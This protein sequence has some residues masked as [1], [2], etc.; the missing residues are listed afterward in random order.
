M[1]PTFVTFIKNIWLRFFPRKECCPHCGVVFINQEITRKYCS[2]RC[3]N[4]AAQ[5]RNMARLRNRGH[6]AFDR[7]WKSGRMSRGQAYKWASRVVRRPVS[8]VHFSTMRNSEIQ[9]LIRCSDAFMRGEFVPEA[10]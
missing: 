6:D 1:R 5:N 10:Y 7:L 2:V 8:D 3:R 4:R 9:T